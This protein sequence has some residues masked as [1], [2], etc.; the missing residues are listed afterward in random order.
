M[1]NRG[2]GDNNLLKLILMVSKRIEIM[3]KMTEVKK[4]VIER[5]LN[6]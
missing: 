5:Y 6:F 1:N 3:M 4:R 2:D